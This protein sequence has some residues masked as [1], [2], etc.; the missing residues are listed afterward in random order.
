MNIQFIDSKKILNLLLICF[1]WPFWKEFLFFLWICC[2]NTDT[3]VQSWLKNSRYLFKIYKCDKTVLH[4]FLKAEDFN[5]GSKNVQ[6]F[7]DSKYNYTNHT[8][9]VSINLCDICKYWLK[10]VCRYNYIDTFIRF[11]SAY[12]YPWKK[13]VCD[14]RKKFIFLVWKLHNILF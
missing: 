12:R 8:F 14:T 3:R 13:I 11:F 7:H 5:G 4:L 2:W 9:K 10:Y 6:L 1:E